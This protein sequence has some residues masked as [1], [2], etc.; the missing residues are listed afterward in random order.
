MYRTLI[1]CLSC[2]VLSLTAVAQLPTLHAERHGDGPARRGGRWRKS[3]NH[4]RR[5][6]RERETTTAATVPLLSPI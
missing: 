1:C 4:Q 2:L 3:G 5:N 6:R